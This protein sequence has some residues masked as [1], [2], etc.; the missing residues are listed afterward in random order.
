MLKELVTRYK[1]LSICQSDIQKS[2]DALIAC[3]NTGGK[4]LT[5]G[6]GGSCADCDQ[7]FR[8]RKKCLC[9]SQ[10]CQRTL[11]YRHW[12][13]RQNNSNLSEI[14]DICIRVPEVETFKVQELHLPIYHFLCAATEAHFFTE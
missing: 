6:N 7:H 13:N 11:P 3:Y 1:Q 8:Q 5:C 4:V 12:S 14:A 2:A 10:S 9:C